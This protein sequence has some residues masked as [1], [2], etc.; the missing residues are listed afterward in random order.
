MVLL[1]FNF[2]P[3]ITDVNVCELLA[4][5]EHKD[6]FKK[7]GFEFSF[8]EEENQ[9]TCNRISI[10]TLP[11]SKNVQFNVDGKWMIVYAFRFQ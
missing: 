11:Y 10:K 3:L 7:N 5:K 6:I 1:N 4:L 8:V 2:R 9:E